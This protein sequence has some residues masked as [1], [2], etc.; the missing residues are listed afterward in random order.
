MTMSQAHVQDATRSADAAINGFRSTFWRRLMHGVRRIRDEAEWQ[1]LMGDDW[2]DRIMDLPVTDQ[3]H[4]KQGRS[5]GRL[6]IDNDGRRRGVFLKRH[7]R[8]PWWKGWLACLWPDRGWS[9]AW[10][11]LEHLEWA[12]RSGLPVPR[13]VAAAEFIGPAGRLQSFLAV[14]ELAG[15]LPLHEMLPRAARALGPADFRAWKAGLIGEIVRLAR[16]LHGRRYFHKDLY[17]CHFFVGQDDLDPSGDWRGRV[18]LIDLHR[19]RRH[20]WA[21]FWWQ[22]K[23]LAQLLFSSDMPEVDRDDRMAFWRQYWDNRHG[24]FRARCLSLMIRI[25]NGLYHRHNRKKQRRRSAGPRT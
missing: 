5:T 1:E 18:H 10:E 24:S 25:K 15:M 23:D 12:R 6:L 19:L 9:P 16:A 22:A 2:P 14:E 7:Y 3:F 11:E 20:A 13:V 17:L 21:S 8:L 4:A